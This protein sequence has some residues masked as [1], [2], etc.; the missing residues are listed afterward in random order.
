MDGVV[1]HQ[2]DR[3]PIH[4]HDLE[5]AQ[6]RIE[7]LVEPARSDAGHRGLAPR[8][9]RWGKVP[10]RF[11]RCSLHSVENRLAH[12]FR[13]PIGSDEAPEGGGRESAGPGV[14]VRRRDD[15]NRRRAARA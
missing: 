11:A 7:R 4:A 1:P 15:E 14:R 6:F 5:E 2:R 3:M 10:L 9:P 12:R 13:F 8:E